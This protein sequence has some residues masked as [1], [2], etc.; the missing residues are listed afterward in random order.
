MANLKV[1]AKVI[2]DRT[3]QEPYDISNAEAPPG[4]QKVNT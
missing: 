1:L 4:W 2:G 3:R